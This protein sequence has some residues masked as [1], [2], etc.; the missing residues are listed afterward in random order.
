MRLGALEAGGTK[1]VCAIGNEN[2]EIFDKVS[3]PTTTPEETIPKL[4]SYFKEKE[5]DAL[6]IGS[7]GPVDVNES[8]PTFGTI[9]TTP[10]EG[11]Q[12]YNLLQVFQKELSCPIGFDTDTNVAALGEATFG[13]TKGL[14]VSMYVT[15]GTGIGIGVLING[16]LLHGMQHPEAGHILLTKHPEDHFRGNCPYHENCFEGLASG[17]AIEARFGAKADTLAERQDVWEMEAY[18]IAQA[19]LNYALILAPRRIVLGGGVMHQE[20]L[21][22]LIREQFAK[23]LGGYFQTKE[24]KDLDHYLVPSMLDGNQGILG[25]FKLA[26]DNL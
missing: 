1:M 4:I 14:D 17:P 24:L 21:F 23:M 11:W 10:K 8:S 12:N 13:A 20:Q 18:Y 19:M 3:I 7:F 16:Q 22:P 25:C 5:I 26:Q 15:I 9:T 6:G 2:G